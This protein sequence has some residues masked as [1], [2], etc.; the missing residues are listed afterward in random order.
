M[1]RFIISSRDI[2]LAK[3]MVSILWL[4]LSKRLLMDIRSCMWRTA[5][6]NMGA[7]VRY[8][9][10]PERLG[11]TGAMVSRKASSVMTLLLMRS[12]AGPESTP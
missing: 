10:L 3:L 4:G 1:C 12:I 8:L 2:C 6:A 11:S 9:I 7:T 5:S